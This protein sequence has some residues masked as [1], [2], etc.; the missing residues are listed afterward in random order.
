MPSWAPPFTGE[1]VFAAFDTVQAVAATTNAH[2]VI[3]E[4]R[5]HPRRLFEADRPWEPRIDN[6]Y[7]NVHHDTAAAP[8]FRLWYD[9]CSRPCSIARLAIGAAAAFSLSFRPGPALV[10]IRRHQGGQDERLPRLGHQGNALRG[11]R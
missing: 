1:R 2:I 3:G 4:V 11:E 5:K 10:M 8:P 6:G 7:P 9:C